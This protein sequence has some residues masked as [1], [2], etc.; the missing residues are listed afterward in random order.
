[1]GHSWPPSFSSS[2]ILEYALLTVFCFPIWSLAS[3]L[4]N[5]EI[6]HS[7]VYKNKHMGD[8]TQKF[9]CND[10]KKYIHLFLLKH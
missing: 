6:T 7:V 9:K 2:L 5:Q 4:E 1:M 10:G 8:E 3:A